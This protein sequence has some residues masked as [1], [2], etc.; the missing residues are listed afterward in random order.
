MAALSTST[1]WPAA[2]SHSPDGKFVAPNPEYRSRDRTE[3]SAY[4]AEHSILGRLD[5]DS[6][7]RIPEILQGH[8]NV[9]NGTYH[10]QLDDWKIRILST[11]SAA[12]LPKQPLRE[13]LF[14]AF[15]ASRGHS[16]PFITR[17][18]V[19]A[20]G[21]SILLQQAVCLAGSL[22]RHPR[23]PDTFIRSQT[24]YEKIRLL[25][26]LDVESD[27]MAILKALCLLTIWCPTPSNISSLAGPWHATG[28]A[29]RLAM[30]LG[31][32][33]KSTY[34]DK[35][36]AQERRK[37]WWFLYVCTALHSIDSH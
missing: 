30:Q 28:T 15:F 26:A 23:L 22:M 12:A 36:N 3:N 29:I 18:D 7:P 10:Q 2:A 8:A 14:D 11:S 25:L 4:I 13:A 34:R 27:M 20:P 32:H 19:E 21:A 9:A 6:L 33:R 24:F 35:P 17:Y 37:L 1:P 16:F 31:M 5:C